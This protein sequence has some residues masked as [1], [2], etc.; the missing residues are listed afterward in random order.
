MFQFPAFAPAYRRCQAFNLTGCPIRTRPDLHSLAV[1]RTFSQLAASFFASGSLGIL[2]TP[3]FP[4]SRCPTCISLLNPLE[5][6]DPN[7]GCEIVFHQTSSSFLPLNLFPVL[8]NNFQLS[9]QPCS[10]CRFSQTGCKDTDFLIT[11]KFFQKYFSIFSSYFSE[12][13]NYINELKG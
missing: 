3:F 11:S 2:H 1:P 7:A 6:P 8:S 4:S 13:L 12:T 5:Y 9:F 10:D